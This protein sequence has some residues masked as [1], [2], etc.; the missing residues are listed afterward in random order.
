MS[1]LDIAKWS[2]RKDIRQNQ[3]YDQMSAGELVQ[4]LRDIAGDDVNIAGLPA[5]IRERSPVSREEFLKMVIPAAH[6][7]ELGFCVHDW[8]F[9]P[10]QLHRDCIHCS[11]HCYIKGDSS[12]MQRVRQCLVEAEQ[13]LVLAEEARNDEYA[14]ADRWTEH[15]RS[16]VARLRNLV[17]IFDDPNHPDGTLI[18]LATPEVPSQIRFA[19]EARLELE[20]GRPTALIAGM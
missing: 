3:A 16:A 10:C 20:G 8:S 17:E 11:E 1:Q 7:T 6:S 2:G 18:R 19:M 12:R 15:Q 5:E 13:Q 14:G 4:R 9:L